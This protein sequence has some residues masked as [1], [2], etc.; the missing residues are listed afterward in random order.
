VRQP[1]ALVRGVGEFVSYTAVSDLRLAA[2]GGFAPDTAL[3]DL[4]LTAVGGFA[5]DT[6][7]SDLQPAAGRLRTIIPRPTT[8][9][10]LTQKC[11]LDR[12]RRRHKRLPMLLD[13]P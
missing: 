8:H 9:A 11:A 3:S 6:A 12:S 10:E 1:S 4:Q 5:P 7:L 13:S 2:V